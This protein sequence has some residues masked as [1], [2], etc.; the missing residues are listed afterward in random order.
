MDHWGAVAPCKTK[1]FEVEFLLGWEATS[2]GNRFP[3]FRDK[4]VVSKYRE[5]ITQ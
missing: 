2:L 5:Q 1:L 3:N 4:V